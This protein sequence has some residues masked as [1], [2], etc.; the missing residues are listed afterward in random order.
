LI[1]W[2]PN[3]FPSPFRCSETEPNGC[4]EHQLSIGDVVEH[5]LD[6][7]RGEADVMREYVAGAAV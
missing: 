2:S 4:R 6:E 3:A 7:V 1:R 5:H